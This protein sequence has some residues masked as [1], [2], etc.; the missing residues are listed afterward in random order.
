MNVLLLHLDAEQASKMADGLREDGHDVT[1]A[2]DEA[3][4][5]AAKP[6]SPHV[7]VVCLDAGSR[8]TLDLAAHRGGAAAVPAAS[9]L[10]VGG[11]TPL[12][13]EAQKRFPNASFSRIDQLST[14]LAS[15]EN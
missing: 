7:L 2:T 3:S 8:R 5:A 11:T 12:L 1:V 15:M 13:R 6:P 10:F 4:V 9:M 14:A